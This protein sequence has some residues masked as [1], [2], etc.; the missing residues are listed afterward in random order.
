MSSTGLSS[1]LPPQQRRVATL[2]LP[3]LPLLLLIAFI[4]SYSNQQPLFLAASPSL[5]SALSTIVDDKLQVAHTQS[6]LALIEKRLHALRIK[7][8]LND[9]DSKYKMIDKE[10]ALNKQALRLLRLQTQ[11]LRVQSERYSALENAALNNYTHGLSAQVIEKGS[12]D[13]EKYGKLAVKFAENTNKIET[14]IRALG[15]LI[16]QEKQQSDLLRPDPQDDTHVLGLEQRMNSRLMRRLKLKLTHRQQQES[17]DELQ[18][19]KTSGGGSKFKSDMVLVDKT[20]ADRKQVELS[21]SLASPPSPS[22]ASASS[23]QPKPVA[24][25][26]PFNKE[27]AMATHEG[28]YERQL[29]MRKAA[30][31]M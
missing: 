18:L 27:E 20:V 25:S 12:K 23:H 14:K 6:Q 13:A 9:D 3:F 5:P 17:R 15:R 28:D 29:V 30:W 11:A 19:K 24:L 8:S 26:S 4:C 2:L 1:P 7:I 10:R 22:P 31:D 21:V 16:R